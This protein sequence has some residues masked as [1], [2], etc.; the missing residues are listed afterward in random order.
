MFDVV[1]AD[2]ALGVSP[3]TDQYFLSPKYEP[4]TFLNMI[5]CVP[6]AY[7][8]LDPFHH[9]RI[10]LKVILKADVPTE[11]LEL[12]KRAPDVEVLLSR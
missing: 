8:P 4:I 2:E 1:K 7:V 9:P 11:I 12:R 10:R 5:R 6:N 3:K